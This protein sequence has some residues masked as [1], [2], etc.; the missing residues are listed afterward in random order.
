MSNNTFAPEAPTANL[1]HFEAGDASFLHNGQLHV[2]MFDGQKVGDK[3]KFI[4]FEAT[5]SGVFTRRVAET[6]IDPMKNIDDQLV[7]WSSRN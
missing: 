4:I 3:E 6:L 1:G 2:A 7:F 5:D